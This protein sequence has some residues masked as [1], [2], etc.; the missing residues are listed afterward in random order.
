MRVLK[1]LA[2]LFL[3]DEA[4]DYLE[5]AGCDVDYVTKNVKMDRG[6]VD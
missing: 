2:Y 3:N 1:K 5:K 6:L 4:L